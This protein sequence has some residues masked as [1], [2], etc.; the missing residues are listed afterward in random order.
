[1]YLN[2]LSKIRTDRP[3][4]Q[5][6]NELAYQKGRIV[7][8][9]VPPRLVV[10][11]PEQE[12][13]TAELELELSRIRYILSTLLVHD[14][15][16]EEFINRQ[17]H[18]FEIPKHSGGMREIT[19]PSETLKESQFTILKGLY[20]L[21]VLPHNAAHGFTKNRNCKTALE[22]HKKHKS[23]WFLKLDIQ[24]FFP[25]IDKALIK[26]ALKSYCNTHYLEEA[27]VDIL[28]TICTK[29]GS[30]PQGAPTSPLLSN[31]VMIE[32]DVKIQA[33]CKAHELVYTRYADDIL[34]S[35]SQSFD[36]EAVQSEII[37][38]LQRG[39]RLKTAKTRYG[40]F[41]GR[42]WNLGLMF[43]N[44]WEITV[45]HANKKKIKNMIHRFNTMP[46]E[47]TRDNMF[48]I[49]GILGYYKFIEPEYFSATP[50]VTMT[51][52]QIQPIMPGAAIHRRAEVGEQIVIIQDRSRH[53]LE[54][55]TVHTVNAINDTNAQVAVAGIGNR[56][57]LHCDY[58]VL[59]T[60]RAVR[61]TDYEVVTPRRRPE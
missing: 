45:G 38:V 2:Y 48:K 35:G 21:K 25:S 19:A 56:L 7:T 14:Q 46:G 51:V 17:Y 1:M 15:T 58:D 37:A 36:W 20:D 43:N 6:D 57:I 61:H 44:N 30:L 10:R 55:G 16:I 23:R 9:L 18:T 12:Q 22:V 11:T 60:E 34:I 59:V 33:I 31:L 3:A 47:K 29:D 8:K 27:S 32:T 26:K 39:M 13:S 5:F 54:N 40:S 41:N 52:Q 50:F 4:E 53:T 24:D 49:N 28:L 42:N